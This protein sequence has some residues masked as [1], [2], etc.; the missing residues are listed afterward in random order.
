MTSRLSTIKDLIK[1]IKNARKKNAFNRIKEMQGKLALLQLQLTELERKNSSPLTHGAQL[2]TS[3]NIQMKRQT[4][5]N[6]I[7]KLS[8][9]I[10]RESARKN[11]RN[12]IIFWS[13]LFSLR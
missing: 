9:I 3:Q 5:S 2:A 12:H 1:E 13:W 11:L 10:A 4:L 8:N 6:E 7:N